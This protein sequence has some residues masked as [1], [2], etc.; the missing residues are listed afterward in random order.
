MDIDMNIIGL[1]AMVIYSIKKLLT[2]RRW[3]DHHV[4]GGLVG[5]VMG[6]SA[7]LV[8]RHLWTKAATCSTCWSCRSRCRSW[9]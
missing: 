3:I 5:V 9:P 7:S 8:H 6:Y 2:N 1:R 4:A